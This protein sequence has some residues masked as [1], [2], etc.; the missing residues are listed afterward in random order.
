LDFDGVVV[1]SNDIKTQAFDRVFSRFPAYKE[2]LM[3]FHFANISLARGEKFNYLLE[4]MAEENNEKLK[5]EVSIEFSEYTTDLILSAPLVKGIENFFNQFS[6]KVPL[7]LASVTPE[8][9]LNLILKY[10]NLNCWF[11]GVYG[12]PPWIKSNAIRDVLLQKG[13]NADQCLLIGDSEG[14]RAAALEVGV[15]FIA[16]NSGLSF[17]E[18]PALIFSDMDEIT[19]YLVHVKL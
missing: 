18:A 19:D 12:C 6:G 3:Q 1:E 5:R 8:E 4:L 9:D 13:I 7:Y 11:D 10:R 16:R 15:R 14:D 2:R 17:K